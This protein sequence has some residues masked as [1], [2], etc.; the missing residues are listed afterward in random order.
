MISERRYKPRCSRRGLK[1][2]R[3]AIAAGDGVNVP[4]PVASVVRDNFVD[5]LAHDDGEKDFAVLGQL[6]AR[7]AGQ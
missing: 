6:A 2:V 1:D 5:A 3:L 4:L 7:R